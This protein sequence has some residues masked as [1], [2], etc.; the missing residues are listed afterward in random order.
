VP[1]LSVPSGLLVYRTAM[2]EVAG[3]KNLEVWYSRL[4]IES[5]LEELAPRLHTT[6]GGA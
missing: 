2:A 6:R 1:H 5:V 3:M 4:E